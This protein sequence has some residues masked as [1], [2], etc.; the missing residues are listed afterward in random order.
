MH[1]HAQISQGRTLSKYGAMQLANFL[2][3]SARTVRASLRTPYAQHGGGGKED[4]ISA[5]ATHSRLTGNSNE[6]RA[7][8]G[9]DRSEPCGQ[10]S[11]HCTGRAQ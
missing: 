5:G 3:I 1:A 4:S 9:R 8:E 11:C 7:G 10:S 6:G 2:E